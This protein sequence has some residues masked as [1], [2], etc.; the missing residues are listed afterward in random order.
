MCASRP[1]Y[2][3]KSC[4]CVCVRIL[5]P[6]CVCVFPPPPSVCRLCRLGCFYSCLL[7]L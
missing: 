5:G 1:K 6:T 4:W 7:L 2:V 3:V